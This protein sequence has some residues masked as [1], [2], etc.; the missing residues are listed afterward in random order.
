MGKIRL[1]V[2]VSL[3]ALLL[4]VSFGC[5]QKQENQGA[6][7]APG[8]K[9]L[10]ISSMED[11]GTMDPHNY[12]SEMFAQDFVYENLLEYGEGGKIEPCLAESWEISPDGKVYTFH[13]RQGVKFSDGSDLNAEVVKKNYDAVLK[14]R[15][16][17]NWLELINQIDKVEAVDTYTFRITFKN[18]YY[19]ALQELTLIRPMRILGMAGFPADGDTSEK[20]EKPIG[21]GPWVLTEHKVG[22]YAVF[23]RNENYWGVKPKLDKVIVKVIPDGDTAAAAL[24]NKEIDMIYGSG[25]LSMDTF[26]QLKESGNYGALISEPMRTRVL[27]VNSNRGATKEL[28][29]RLALQYAID[30]QAIIDNVFYGTETKADTLFASNV[31]YCDL[32]LEVR[33]YD[34]AKAQKLLD[35]AG[36]VL[37]A[38][39]EYRE[40]NGQVLKLDL[41]YIAANNI[42]KAAVQIIQA[43]LKKLGVQVN[44]VGEEDQSFYQRQK[45]GTFD[46]ITGETWGA[47]YDPHSMVSSM[48]EPS[49]F[50]YQAQAGLPMKKEIDEKIGQVLLSTDEGK[51]QDLYRDIL[52]TL[53]EQAVYLPISYVTNTAVFQKNVTGVEF[54]TSNEIPLINVDKE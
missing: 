52:T 42:D 35:D 12:A 31:P 25:A 7:S 53:H 2:V 38:G 39:K 17:H 1:M 33:N 36:W 15:E 21:T 51:R 8:E 32:G 10:T 20:I 45:D 46:L 23:T 11:I 54:A 29:V 40:K 37:P 4:T 50:D 27:G 49:H 19:P 30:K 47:P 44:L 26:K 41:C 13:L 34:L 16:N 3:F 22:E 48:R 18:P 43:D 5:G 28:P 24:E 9:V 6:D 14:V